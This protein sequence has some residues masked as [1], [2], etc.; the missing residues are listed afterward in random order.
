MATK[1]PTSR[2][3]TTKTA[4]KKKEDGAEEPVVKSEKSKSDNP[5]KGAAALGIVAVLI[6]LTIGGYIASRYF[7]PPTPNP[8]LCPIV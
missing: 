4:K 2:R 7:D 3:K 6:G 8:F 5:I 1:K